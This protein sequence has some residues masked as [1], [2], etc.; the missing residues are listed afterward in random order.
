MP[1]LT[2][3]RRLVGYEPKYDLQATLEQVVA[4]EQFQAS[5]GR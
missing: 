4:Y 1:D 3:I 2:K 5:G